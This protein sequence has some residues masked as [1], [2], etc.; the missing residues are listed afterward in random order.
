MASKIYTGYAVMDP[1]R[2]INM[3]GVQTFVRISDVIA[4]E[5]AFTYAASVNAAREAHNASPMYPRKLDAVTVV[6]YPALW[7]GIPA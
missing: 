1:E 7:N 2:L 5:R 6:E 4:Q 3:E